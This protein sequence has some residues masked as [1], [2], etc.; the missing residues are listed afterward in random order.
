MT[1]ED[2]TILKLMTENARLREAL[3][4]AYAHAESVGFPVPGNIRQAALEA[5]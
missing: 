1:R 3:E 2:E 5:K 4:A